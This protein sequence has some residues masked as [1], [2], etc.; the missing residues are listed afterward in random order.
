MKLWPSESLAVETSLTPDVVYRLLAESTEPRKTFRM[1][2]DHRVFQGVVTPRKFEISRIIHYRNSFLP[3]ISGS[4]HPS[5]IG[6][7]LMIRIALNP[8]GGGLAVLWLGFLAVVSLGFVVAFLSGHANVDL[9]FLTPLWMFIGF[10]V[11]VLGAFW[12][13]AKKAK[14]VL[15]ALLSIGVPSRQ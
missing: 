4:I 12:F 7:R 1:V 3:L 10:V 11:L 5:P 8:I 14:A 2:R 15:F 6:T 13:E 9:R